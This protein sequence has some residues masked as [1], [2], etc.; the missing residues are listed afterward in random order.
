MKNAYIIKLADRETPDEVEF[1]LR[2]ALKAVAGGREYP[3]VD[4]AYRGRGGIA[5]HSCNIPGKAV[6][7]DESEAEEFARSLAQT[8]GHGHCRAVAFSSYD[9]EGKSA[10]DHTIY[11]LTRIP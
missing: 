10:W 7:V 5:G 2:D 8:M 3:I 9:I 11:C 6:V 4:S 1:H